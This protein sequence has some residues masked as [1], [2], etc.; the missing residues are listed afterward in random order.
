MKIPICLQLIGRTVEIKYDEKLCYE[1]QQYGE[2]NYRKVR[3]TLSK[4][5]DA[6]EL[7]WESQCITFLHEVLHM[8]FWLLEEH[9]LRDNEAFIGRLSEVLYQV[10]IQIEGESDKTKR[11]KRRFR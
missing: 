9:S 8:T 10:I 11:K 5:C 4:M 2:S 3:I 6:D 7:S 1:K